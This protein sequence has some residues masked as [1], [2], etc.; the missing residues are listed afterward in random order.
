MDW[1]ASQATV[2]GVSESDMTKRLTLS[3]SKTEVTPIFGHQSPRNQWCP[4]VFPSPIL[5]CTPPVSLLCC[6][7]CPIHV[8]TFNSFSWDSPSG[9][10]V[11]TPC[12][13]SRGLGFN[14]WLGN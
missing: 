6:R 3:L 10:V 14:P 1:G 12:S 13:Q 8:A 5:L 9:P 2:H 11:K 7:V 4:S